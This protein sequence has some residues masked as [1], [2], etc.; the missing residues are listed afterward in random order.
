MRIALSS[1]KDIV[2]VV[3]VAVS[4]ILLSGNVWAE[5]SVEYEYSSTEYIE[6]Q[7]QVEK[8]GEE[9]E[10]LRAIA[11]TAEDAE[12]AEAA[13]YAEAA[14]DPY[15]EIG[16]VPGYNP[17]AKYYEVPEGFPKIDSRVRFLGNLRGTWTEMGYQYGERAGDL[18]VNVFDYSLELFNQ[19]NM[20]VEKL[21]EY[22]YRYLDEIDAYAPEMVRFMEGIAEG[23]STMLGES[24]FAE[25]MS[26]FEKI[27]LVN[28]YLD[29]DF[30]PPRRE[31][32]ASAESQLQE[33]GANEYEWKLAFREHCTG[34]ALSGSSTGN[35][36]SPTKNGETIIANNCDL[37]RF[38]PFGW[39]CAYVATPD[40]PDANVFWSIH[41][42][43]LVGGL[44][45]CTNDKGVTL[46]NFF[47]GQSSDDSYD[48]GVL[49]GPLQI[50]AVAYADTAEEA[51]D[52]MVFGNEKYRKTTGRTKV[53]QTGLWAYI[54]SDST[55]VMVLE[56]TPRRHAVRYPGDMG[57]VG[58]YVIYAN[59][60]STDHYYDENNILVEEPIGIYPP[61][62][63]ERYYTYDWFIKY[64][65]GELDEELVKEGQKITYYFD[66][67]TGRKI[68][69][70]EGSTYPLYIGVH[71]ISAYWGA[72]LGMDIG[73]TAH[74][75]QVVQMPSGR[76]KI[77][78]VQGRPCEWIGPWQSTDFYGYQK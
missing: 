21:L 47:G 61:E 68:E 56:L 62:F 19:R 64:H 40:D 38:V 52:I 20:T 54:V 1:K 22:L 17:R 2:L 55:D 4:F 6:L 31:A 59:W 9:I 41:P 35:L 32:S 39:N 16:S 73:G 66:E 46:G 51:V 26:D 28:A 11:E 25:E 42:A 77:N 13:E 7:A 37:A 45:L 33:N 44:N 5:G 10:S 29:L 30:F 67:E 65:F 57:E 71:T 58:N 49:M 50:H 24:R 23:A 60:Y 3:V 15:R 70:L 63:P 72:A 53:L 27:L 34:I 36:L 18:I 14:D 74:A 75:S 8:L 48:F 78:W 43:G 12:T 69:F 76:K